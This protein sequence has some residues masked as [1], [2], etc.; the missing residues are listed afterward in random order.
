MATSFSGTYCLLIMDN[1]KSMNCWILAIFVKN[2]FLKY[3][4]FQN[5]EKFSLEYICKKNGILTL[6]N[7]DQPYNHRI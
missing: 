7:F 3:V 5:L 1:N 4:A 6:K 2:Q